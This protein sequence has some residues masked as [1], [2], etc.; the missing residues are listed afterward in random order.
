MRWCTLA[1]FFCKSTTRR[2]NFRQR[3]VG[4]P[5]CH[6]KTTGWFSKP[7]S[8]QVIRP[9]GSNLSIPTGAGEKSTG[10]A[11]TVRDADVSFWPGADVSG[12][13]LSGL[14]DP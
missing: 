1:Y 8:A 7:I 3:S 12:H 9:S 5:P 14:S 13:L 6:E 4:S 11:G 10:A 2:K